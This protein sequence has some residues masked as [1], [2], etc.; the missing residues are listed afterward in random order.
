MS[1]MAVGCAIAWPMATIII[2]R[3][4]ALVAGDFNY[5]IVGDIDNF[6][7]RCCII[8]GAIL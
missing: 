7:I 4:C 1:F 5:V 3:F 2:D 6:R 8:D